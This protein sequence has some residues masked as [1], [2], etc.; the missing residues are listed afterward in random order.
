MMRLT[1]AMVA[2]TCLFLTAPSQNSV[3]SHGQLEWL[4][5]DEAMLRAEREDKH[6]LMDVYT[7]WCGWC[8][9]MDAKT[10][11]DSRVTGY[12][13]ERFILIKLN[14]ETDGNVTYKGKTYSAGYFSQ[15]IG[16]N[17][18]PATAFFESNADMVTL[19][20]GY[21]EADEFLRILEYISDK[22]YLKMSF[23]DFL[24]ARGYSE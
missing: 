15:A 20:P 24:R 12:L 14:P 16:V 18:Y 6:V 7:D 5:F 1:A 11:G 21:V 8:K 10:Y 4:S 19:V 2:L 9:T 3:A 23:P 22:Y 13:N 17:G